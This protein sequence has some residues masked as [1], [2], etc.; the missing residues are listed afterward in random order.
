MEHWDYLELEIQTMAIVNLKQ[1]L[2]STSA[3]INVIYKW[4]F[5]GID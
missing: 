3:A 1:S 2:N 4:V 5:S